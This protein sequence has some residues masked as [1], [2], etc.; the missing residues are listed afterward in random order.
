MACCIGLILK[1]GSH[2]WLLFL[3]GSDFVTIEEELLWK[4]RFKT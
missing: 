2:H 3:R 1:K 4:E